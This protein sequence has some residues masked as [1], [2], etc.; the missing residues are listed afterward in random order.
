MD[1]ESFFKNLIT[2][3]L[4]ENYSV[5]T[6]VDNILFKNEYD[7]KMSVELLLKLDY[8]KTKNL[9]GETLFDTLF[10][11]NKI[12]DIFSVRWFLKDYIDLNQMREEIKSHYKML[13]S[14]RIHKFTIYLEV[15]NE[16]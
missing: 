7:K 10:S 12:I 1:R 11:E 2:E 9:I 14:E 13:Y 6:G 8:F 3:F 5:V 16:G 4:T 15:L